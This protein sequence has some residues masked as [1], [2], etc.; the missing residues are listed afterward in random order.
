M[1]VAQTEP[2]EVRN[3]KTLGCGISKGMCVP[4]SI[5]RTLQIEM[6][7]DTGE[8][9]PAALTLAPPSRARS[10]AEH[11]SEAVQPGSSTYQ[12]VA[13]TRSLKLWPTQV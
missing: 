13:T 4:R 12:S 6:S 1:R 9:D 3:E 10:S 7:T 11:C 2:V 8:N 5:I